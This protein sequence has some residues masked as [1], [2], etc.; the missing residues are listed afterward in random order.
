MPADLLIHSQPLQ[1]LLDAVHSGCSDQEADE[2]ADICVSEA[3]KHTQSLDNLREALQIHSERTPE[4]F[5]GDLVNL[6]DELDLTPADWAR[7]ARSAD[8]R[9]VI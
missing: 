4:D 1:R 5:V 6:L 7:L 9:V 8:K 2:L 3:D